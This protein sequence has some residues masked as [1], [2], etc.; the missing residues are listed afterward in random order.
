MPVYT[1]QPDA[2]AA[3]VF[4]SL[5]RRFLNALLLM[6]LVT[7]VIV[8]GFFTIGAVQKPDAD[9]GNHWFEAVWNTLNLVSTVGSL[10]LASPLERAWGMLAIVI[11]LGAVLYGFGTLMAMFTGDVA[12]MLE[13]RKMR[14]KLHEMKDHIVV[15]GYGRVGRAVASDLRRHGASLVVI[16]SDSRAVTIAHDDGHTAVQGDCTEDHT[17][18][19]SSIDTARG[20]IAA[21]KSDA[22]NVYL[23]L[24]AREIQPELRILA[25]AERSETRKRLLRAGA[26][27]VIAPSD[28]A[29]HQLSHLMLKP[30]VSEFVA[31]ATGEGEYDF[32]EMEVAQHPRLQEKAL[33]DLDLPGRAE[34]IVISVVTESGQHEFNPRS[35]RVLKAGD[36]LVLVCREGG[37]KQIEALA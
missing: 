28:L 24:M 23:I 30:L 12:R 25:R 16:D 33:G 37:L 14:R 26:D 31:A 22:T 2:V 21:L 18:R 7:A 17:L 9:W 8:L 4:R 20:L 3:T 27:R 13:R 10:T 36:T 19:E 29:A 34:A 15:C 6:A 5:R 1:V 35:E 11:G 32:A